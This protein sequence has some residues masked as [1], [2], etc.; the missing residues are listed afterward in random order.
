MAGAFHVIVASDAH[1]PASG[2]MARRRLREER[3]TTP[4]SSVSGHSPHSYAPENPL[5]LCTDAT[6]HSGRGIHRET[7][8]IYHPSCLSRPMA[9]IGDTT[10]PELKSLIHAVR[11]QRAAFSIAGGQ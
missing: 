6:S 11:K 5:H 2:V 9:K 7:G 8:C 10:R 1:L 3:M 4:I